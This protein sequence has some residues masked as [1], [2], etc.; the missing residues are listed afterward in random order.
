M[1]STEVARSGLARFVPMLSWLPK[2]Q[3][4]WLCIDL[5]AV[6]NASAVVFPQSMEAYQAMEADS[7][8]VGMSGG[9]AV[10]RK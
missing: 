6:L 2:Y 8:E 10:T 1:N 7:K 5:V 9:N 3:K 4:G